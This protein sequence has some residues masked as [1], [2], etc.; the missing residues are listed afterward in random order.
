MIG[1]KRMIRGSKWDILLVLDACRYDFFRKVYPDHLEGTLKK[2][3]SPVSCKKGVATSEWAKA[4]FQE[5]YDDVIYI[6]S[7]PHI[8]SKMAVNGF[9][10]SRHFYKVIDV[11]LHEWDDEKGTVLPERVSDTVI[12]TRERYPQER[13]I[14]HYMQPHFPYLH[15]DNP[16][17]AKDSDPKSH[18]NLKR[19]AKNFI[20]SRM[21]RSLGGGFTR[22]L[23]EGIGLSP[24]TPMH[25]VLRKEGQEG[26]LGAY[27]KNLDRVLDNIAGLSDRLSDRMVITS[28]HGEYLGEDDFYGHSYLPQ[29]PVLNTVP[30]F[31]LGD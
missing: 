9:E 30:W 13:I 29:H 28:D 18:D 1:Q 24:I 14:A 21:R 23:I 10:G 22:R 5:R 8:N 17:R 3:Y 2:V 31:E 19:R 15:I 25:E 7:T 6:S 26:L 11:W 20:G 12:E 27:E 4:V 16:C